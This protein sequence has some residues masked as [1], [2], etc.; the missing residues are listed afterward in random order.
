MFC[1]ISITVAASRCTWA[2]ARD[3][4]IPLASTFATVHPKLH[5]PIYSLLLVTFVQLLLGLINLGSTSAFTAFV[6]VGV[7]ALSVSYAIPI[8]LSLIGDRRK[9]VN[10]AK[11]NC[12]NLVGTIVN[13]V[14]LVWIGCEVVLFS[15]PSTLPVTTVSMNYASVVLVGFGVLSAGWYFAYARKG[16]FLMILLYLLYMIGN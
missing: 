5:V 4:A 16:M 13:I 1:S 10:Q 12:G 14:A 15:M 11:W 7:I 9:E 6:S 8:A 3:N 2:F